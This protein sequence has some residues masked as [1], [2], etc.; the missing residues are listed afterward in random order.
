[1]DVPPE[2][3]LDVAPVP[4]RHRLAARRRLQRAGG[5]GRRRAGAA[6]SLLEDLGDDLF[7]ALCAA[8]ADARGRALRRRDRP[9][10]RPAAPR[11]RPAGTWAGRRRPTTWPSCCAR[12]GWSPSGTCPPRPAQPASAD[13]AA[14]FDALRR[15]GLRR[16]SLAA[17][18][19]AVL[20][21][22]HAENLIWLPRRRG[23]RPGRH[24]RLPGHA[25]RPS[26]PTTSSRCSRTP[27]ATS[28]RSCAPRCS[29]ATSRAAAPTRR[30]SARAA[31]ALAAQRNLKILGLFTRLCRR[32]GKPRYLGYLPRVWAHLAGDLAHPGAGAAR[33]LAS[34]GTCRRPRPE[35]RAPHR[36]RA[37]DARGGDDLRRRAR[38]PDGRADPRPAE[39]AD[40]GRRARR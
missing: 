31:H 1:M 24:A 9:P 18:P 32:D 7:A 33:G 27:G 28:R 23:A 38:H 21:D 14:E 29:R 40:R 22:Y 36:G 2:S 25:G 5:A 19:V 37:H 17:P 16:R 11:R 12:R 39:A 13:L 4:R 3:G 15:G 10:R 34:P 6:W 30:P 35:V 20:R 26:R 8:R